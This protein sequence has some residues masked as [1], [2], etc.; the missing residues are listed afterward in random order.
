MI[1]KEGL[2]GVLGQGEGID[3][4]QNGLLLLQLSVLVPA[5]LQD[6]GHVGGIFQDLGQSGGVPGIEVVFRHG[7][8]DVGQAEGDVLVDRHV[9][10]QGIVLEEEAH[11]PLVGRDVDAHVAVEY[12][13]VANGDPAAGGGLQSGDHPQGG[14]LAAAGGAQQGHKGVVGN[15]QVQVFYGVEFAPALGNM[16]QFDFRH[17]LT[18]NSFVQARAGDLVYQ[19]VANQDGDD[20]YQVDAAGEGVQAHLVEV[21]QGGG[22]DEALDAQQHE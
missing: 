12:H 3:E 21:V 15:G 9:G 1:A 4:L 7:L 22:Q 6:G 10:P 20:Q 5:L 14:G 2:G 18:S 8:L 19:G 16:F 13:L 17:G 11:L